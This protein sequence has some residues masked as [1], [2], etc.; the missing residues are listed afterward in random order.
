M[1]IYSYITAATSRI[2]ASALLCL[3]LNSHAQMNS[4][5]PVT[6]DMDHSHMPAAV[7]PGAPIP[8]LSL[9]I[10]RDA[11]S[12]FN[13]RLVTENFSLIP[14][15]QGEM[16]MAQLM[17]PSTDGLTGYV[18]GHAHLYVNGVKIQRLY[19]NYVHL[20]ANLLRGGVNQITVTINNHGHMYW[21]V[22]GRQILATVFLQQGIEEP[23]VYRFESFPAPGQVFILSL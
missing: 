23:V 9:T 6:T 20:P 5:A 14:P 22:D 10:D 19:G 1:N 18:E 12:G 8:A 11:M 3:C 7:P 16:D 21:S 4:S 2:L 17:A 13:L 15:P